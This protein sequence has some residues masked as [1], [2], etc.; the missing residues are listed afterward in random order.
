MTTRVVPVREL[1]D[2]TGYTQSGGVIMGATRER[3]A[4]KPS[5]LARAVHKY[6]FLLLTTALGVDLVLSRLGFVYIGQILSAFMVV[7]Y[8]KEHISIRKAVCSF[9]NAMMDLYFKEIS[10]GGVHKL[11]ALQEDH[12][13][14]VI[15]ACAPHVNQFLDPIVVMKVVSETTGRHVSWMTAEKSYQRKWIGFFARAM[16]GIPVSRPDDNERAGPGFITTHGTKAYGHSG[17][18]FTSDF[19]KGAM[20]VVKD[21]KVKK[22]AKIAQVINDYEMVL[23]TPMEPS[24]KPVVQNASIKFERV[25]SPLH[26]VL[27]LVAVTIP[28]CIIIPGLSPQTLWPVALITAFCLACLIT[29]VIYSLRRDG[30]SGK[31]LFGGV[32]KEFKVEDSAEIAEVNEK[33]QAV[34]EDGSTDVTEKKAYRLQPYIDQSAMFQEVYEALNQG[35][36]IG[37]FPEGGTH[38]GTQLLPLKWGIS[39]MLLGAMAKQE[40]GETKKIS[41]V[42][43]G[44]NY[45][46]PHKF[47]STVSVDFGDPIEVHQDMALKWKYGSKEVKQECNQAV[48]E[49]VMFGVKSCIVQAN[50]MN[51][52]DIFRTIRRLYTPS[53]YRLS[54][55]DNVAL[56]QGF[57]TGF[58]KIKDNPKV[59]D[60][61]KRCFEYNQMLSA[62]RVQD[63]HV[64]RFQKNVLSAKD[65]Q[66]LIFKTAFRLILLVCF[67]G[68][69]IPWVVCAAP[70]GLFLSVV[71]DIKAKE[72]QKM[73]VKGTWKVLLSTVVL[74][75]LHV[76]C[77]VGAGLSFG[78]IAALI[79]FF[80]APL[81]A[82]AAIFAF[83]DGVRLVKSLNAYFLLLRKKDV[84]QQLFEFRESLKRDIR[85]IKE[86]NNWL[87][88]LDKETR[89]RLETRQSFTETDL[90]DVSF[91]KI[92]KD[93]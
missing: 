54:V 29:N 66:S 58:S 63:H 12:N 69:A 8:I 15:F 57:A 20:L 64:Q 5:G 27:I 84:G 41:V 4:P 22:T 51:T 52:L 42:P 81:G 21:G 39:V 86:E 53:G 91:E 13:R 6:S 16:K 62:Y 55:A 71:S 48:M 19:A 65:R 31:E 24:H 80:F 78:E 1:K 59:K 93:S 35:G 83:E 37:I 61:M 34:P 30:F 75:V 40:G 17:T 26:T 92:E 56:T 10:V 60:V 68:F 7:W 89:K 88:Q 25:L 14:S 73:S 33:P 45:F 18:K 3:K 76:C 85:K 70:V 46:A 44:L 43:V 11:A 74:P 87:D 38:D 32:S 72:V 47:R 23:A 28:L 82:V 79:W 2:S 77:T 9:W 50:D 36:N 49:L 90:S 67:G